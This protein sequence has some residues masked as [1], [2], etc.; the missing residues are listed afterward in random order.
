[1]NDAW[2]RTGYVRRSAGRDLHLHAD[3][4]WIDGLSRAD[5]ARD[6]L[7]GTKGDPLKR[8]RVLLAKMFPLMLDIIH[9]LPK[10]PSNRG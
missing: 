8:I 10:P 7:A 6:K 2:R 5:A 3:L 9:G 1:V 4:H